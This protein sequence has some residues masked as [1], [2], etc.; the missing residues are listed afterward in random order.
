MKLPVDGDGGNYCCSCGCPNGNQASAPGQTDG[1][2][3]CRFFLL[4]RRFRP[5]GFLSEMHK[6]P[7]GFVRILDTII[8][9]RCIF[10]R[11]VC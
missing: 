1:C 7:P 3:L 2:C 9:S 4:G 10:R 5:V 6:V 8:P 11:A